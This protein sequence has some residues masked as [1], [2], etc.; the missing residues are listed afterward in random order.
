MQRSPSSPLTAKGKECKLCKAKGSGNL[1]HLH[2]GSP[3]KASP[4]K[5]SISPKTSSPKK[6]HYLNNLPLPA[7]ERVL[8]EMGEKE[9]KE[10]CSTSKHALKIC[11]EHNFRQKWLVRHP[12]KFFEGFVLKKKKL[13]K[14]FGI[15]KNTER[16]KEGRRMYI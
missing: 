3:K 15:K 11:R 4:K 9:L 2:G 16:I 12:R 1:C 10:V 13:D 8:L 7:L 14:D 5:R 6:F